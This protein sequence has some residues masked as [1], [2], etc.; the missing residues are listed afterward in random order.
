MP[1]YSYKARDISGS[2]KSG[3]LVEENQNSALE[4]LDRMGLFPVE[5]KERGE[6]AHSV[7][8]KSGGKIK[9]VDILVFTQELGDLVGAGVSIDKSLEIIASHTKNQKM[10]VMIDEISKDITNGEMLSSAL[11]KY[12]ENFSTLYV[13]MVRA[14]EAGG[15]LAESLKR[16]S[17]LYERNEE[18]SSKIRGALAYP[19]LLSVLAVVSI[20]F[21]L[22]YF[23]PKFS[24]I[25][26]TMKASLPLPTQITIAASDFMRENVLVVGAAISILVLLVYR[27]F[28][29]EAGK[30]LISKILLK[31]P[32]AGRLFTEMAVARFA[33]VLGN[34]LKNRVPIVD[35]VAIARHA[36]GSPILVNDLAEV[37]PGLRRGERLAAM[38]RQT[39]YFPQAV[40]DMIAVGEESGNIDEVLFRIADSYE[41]RIDRTIRSLL[42]LFEPMMLILMAAIIG[43][44]VISMLLPIF[45]ISA[46]VK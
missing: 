42:S 27:L 15:F 30:L 45:T 32:V 20:L 21:L 46:V 14:G 31:V 35:S 23:I 43:F 5:V 26:K 8:A 36:A 24:A 28:T 37:E 22:V 38:L 34:L 9:R 39:R 41:V 40:A 4:R 7:A 1:S 19:I 2:L 3:V 33:R 17:V 44:I 6:I 25:F 12:P 29:T 18:I 13:S 10:S 16:L 11:A